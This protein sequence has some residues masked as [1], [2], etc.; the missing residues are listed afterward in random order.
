L[1][2][3]VL[4]RHGQSEANLRAVFAGHT[5]APLTEMGE[6]QAALTAAYICSKYQVDEVYASDLLRAFHTGK[7]VADQLGLQTVPDQALREI[8]AGAW[9]NRPF[10]ELIDKKDKNYETWRFDIGKAT[11]TDGESVAELQLRIVAELKKI[12]EDQQGKTVVIATHATPIRVFQCHCEGKPIQ[13]LREISWVS[14]ASVTEAVYEDGRFTLQEVGH[15]AHL[16]ELRSV[17][18]KNV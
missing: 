17:L 4:I 1:T 5:N 6:K 14:N 12:A 18:P 2:R 3:L 13:D 8:Y 9:E 15:D 7:A 10:Q 11:C 16:G